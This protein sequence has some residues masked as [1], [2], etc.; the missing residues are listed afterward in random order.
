MVREH[1]S[2]TR[3]LVI[4][5]LFDILQGYK[6]LNLAIEYTPQMKLSNHIS[7]T[8]HVEFGLVHVSNI[9][10]VHEVGRDEQVTK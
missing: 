5:C 7:P 8:S 9:G 1:G 2:I 3:S 6:C 4:V 10:H